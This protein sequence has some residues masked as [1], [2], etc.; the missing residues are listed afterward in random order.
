MLYDK[1]KYSLDLCELTETFFDE[2]YYIENYPDVK[3]APITPFEHY[4]NYGWSEGRNPS[5]SFNTYGYLNEYPDVAESGINPLYHYVVWGMLEGRDKGFQKIKT[6][7]SNEAYRKMQRVHVDGGRAPDYAPRIDSPVI[8]DESDPKV[9]AFYLPQFHPFKENNEWWGKGFTEWSNVAKAIPQ[10]DGHYQPRLPNDLGYYDLRLP[11]VMAEQIEMAKS[12]GVDAFCFH[13]YWFAG[14]R[15]ME[16]PIEQYLENKDMLDLP[17]C[18]CWANENWSRRWDGSENDILIAQEHSEQDNEA[19]FYDLLRHFTDE[20]Y[21]KVNGKPFIIIYRPDIIPN[22]QSL[23]KQWRALAIK[24]G[25]PGLHLVATNSF[26]FNDYKELGFDGLVEFPPHNVV[27][28]G[29][30][31]ELDFYNE[32][33][34]GTVYNYEDVVNFCVNRLETLAENEESKAYY[35]TVM[36][37]WDNSARKPGKGNV[38][39]GATPAKFQNWLSSCYNWSNRIHPDGERFV[40][41]NAWNEWAEGTYLEPDKKYGYA[42]LN[43]VRST[44]NENHKYNL[45]EMLTSYELSSKKSD[46]IAVIHIFYEDLIND[47]HTVISGARKL[48]DFDVA[49]SVPDSFSEKGLVK[50]IE[51]LNPVHVTISENRGRDVWPFI[52][53]VSNIKHLKYRYGVKLHSKKSTHLSSG[54]DWRK[55]I[56]DALMSD[57]SIRKVFDLFHSNEKVGIVFPEHFKYDLKDNY[58]IDNKDNLRFLCEIYDVNFHDMKEFV[59]GT[60]FWFNFELINNLPSKFVTRELFGPE[61]GAI[62]GTMAHAYERFINT[63]S[64]KY[65][66]STLSYS[67][68]DSYRAY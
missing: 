60:M 14:H 20:R 1:D 40:F 13:Y 17:F 57:E 66:F 6:T 49:I 19:V 47:F 3:E 44:I 28:G 62:D 22:I 5:D 55:S 15:L 30:N 68:K 11:E 64:S 42:Y 18:L 53:T 39:H 46:S 12:H 37:A 8:K 21:V 61:L 10:F 27:A 29:K 51:K 45:S 23:T 50:A 33:F 2:N 26:G 4:L 9:I 67:T 58:L 38:F 35:P 24:E 65:G 34:Q 16:R 59:A 63:F 25:L 43:A 36:T 7:E 52:Q 48:R 56:F 54:T 41:I 32:D 31:S